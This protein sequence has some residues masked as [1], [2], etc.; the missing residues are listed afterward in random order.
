M[1]K[2]R[3]RFT[4]AFRIKPGERVKLADHDPG[5]DAGFKDEEATKAE[6]AALAKEIDI[7]EVPGSHDSMLSEPNVSILAAKLRDKLQ[8]AQRRALSL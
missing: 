3:N 7:C 5:D 2:D 1:A 6:T 8:A 4:D